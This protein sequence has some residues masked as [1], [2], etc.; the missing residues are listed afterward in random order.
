MTT[1]QSYDD[2]PYESVPITDT[3]PDYLGALARLFGVETAPV[4]A[5]RVLELGCAGGGNLV[6]MAFH[7]PGSRFVG[8]DLARAHVDE[9]SAWISELGLDNIQV[10]HRS[11]SD[12]LSDL[13]EF[14]YILAH[15]LY[16]WVPRPVQDAILAVC[17]RQLAA[18][19]V[20]YVSYN[21]LPGWHAR[22]GLRAMLLQHCAAGAPA[23]QR[24]A[25]AHGLFDFLEPALRL[26]PAD[27]ARGLLAEIEYLR[28]APP[29]YVYHEY[30]EETNEP[31]WFGEFMARARAAGLDYLADAGIASMLPETLGQEAEAMLAGET[32]RIRREQLMDC[33]RLRK[34]RRTLLVRRGVGGRERPDLEAF[35][36]LAL[37]ADLSRA[38]EIDLASATPEEFDLPAGGHCVLTHPVAKAAAMLLASRYPDSL[39]WPQLRAGAEDLLAAHGSPLAGAAENETA[40]LSELYS[41]VAHQAARVSRR[42]QALA[43]DDLPARPAAHALA[44]SQ[45]GRGRVLA[46]SRHVAV[47]LDPHGARLVA[48]LDGS[49]DLDGL[50]A[51]L[52]DYLRAEG[53]LPPEHAVLRDAVHAL[54]WTLARGGALSTG[55][56]EAA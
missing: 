39:S 20:A 34:F 41:L 14:D 18:N 45:A 50:T 15:G 2:L 16:S 44:R 22:A 7:L 11:V 52:S 55:G 24:L 13:G 46:S 4:E 35:R 19:G 23:S 31:V 56:G 37:H 5:C 40:L 33:A 51:W 6:P 48:A 1:L 8:I 29:S 12:D 27:D 42:A 26:N 9:A 3:H 30:L 43:L 10:L 53:L 38:G 28:R 32:D 54:L 49:R 21:T 36:G 17:A 47:D 25:Q